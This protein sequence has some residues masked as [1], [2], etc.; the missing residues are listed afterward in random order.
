VS[1]LTDWQTAV[2]STLTAGLTE[3]TIEEGKR[4]GPSRDRNLAVVF[5]DDDQ[6]ENPDGNVQWI[7]PVLR[8]RAWLQNPKQ[9]KATSPRVDTSLRDLLEQIETILQPG[10]VLPDVGLGGLYF[11]VT[12]TKIDRV[13]W[14]VELVLTGWAENPAVLA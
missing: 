4:D 12:G 11:F 1:T 5:A 14:G 9:V 3:F 13:D 7:R 6:P 2:V 10:Q 8:V